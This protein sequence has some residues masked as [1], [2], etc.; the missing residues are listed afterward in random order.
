MRIRLTSK[1]STS[2]HFAKGDLR[3]ALS[4]CVF[5]MSTTASIDTRTKSLFNHNVSC[6][7][8]YTRIH[9]TQIRTHFR[10]PNQEKGIAPNEVPG[11]T[12]APHTHPRYII[13]TAVVLSGG[14]HRLYLQERRS[15]TLLSIGIERQQFKVGDDPKKAP[16]KSV[17]GPSQ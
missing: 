5:A 12:H 4:P 3:K 17:V 15:T 7:N 8:R 16:S 10:I 9:N 14:L 11:H 2:F 13:F 6:T 1:T